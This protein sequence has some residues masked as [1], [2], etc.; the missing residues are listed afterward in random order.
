LSVARSDYVSPAAPPA[1]LAAWAVGICFFISGA[2]G[3]IYQ[4]IWVR[5]MGLFY[6]N[7]TL[8]VSS[9][10]AA[11]MGGLA[12]G[13]WL[14]GAFSDRIRRPIAL[15]GVL[16]ILIGAYGLASP[17]VLDLARDYYVGEYAGRAAGTQEIALAQLGLCF[18]CLILPTALMGATLPILSAGLQRV[19]GDVKKTVG[20]LYALNTFG[21]VLGTFLTAF[22]LLPYIGVTY[23]I[24]T[25]VVANGLIGVAMILYSMLAGEPGP[26]AAEQEESEEE[27][28]ELRARRRAL[29]P[30]VKP[31]PIALLMLVFFT[32]GL[33]A[34]TL[35]VAWTRT[36]CMFLGSSVYGFALI[37]A[38]FLIGIALGS[39][40]F[41][42]WF[43]RRPVTA[44]LLG[45]VAVAIGFS[46]L[47]LST[48]F[49]YLPYSFLGIYR[50][51]SFMHPWVLYGLQFGLCLLVTLVPTTLMGMTFPIVAKLCNDQMG[52]VGNAVGKSYAANTTGAILGSALSALVFIPVLG[53][54]GTVLWFS[55]LYVIVGAG[56]LMWC[57]SYRP[58]GS[59]TVYGTATLALLVLA[60]G[61]A[62]YAPVYLPWSKGALT[63]G[64]FRANAPGE[65]DRMLA[66]ISAPD[67][68]LI[69]YAEGTSATVSVNMTRHD[70]EVNKWLTV[71]GKT[72][73]STLEGDT[74]TQYLTG[75][76]P[77]LLNENP[78]RCL[79][80]GLGSGC[81][82]AA[83][84][85]YDEVKRVEV[86]EIEEQVLEGAKLMTELNRGV[87]EPGVEPK[88]EVRIMDGR[89]ALLGNEGAYDVIISE[90]S[91]PWI[92]GVSSLF[93]VE[94]YEAC[95]RALTPTGTYCQWA[96]AY[97]L[98]ERTMRMMFATVQKVF[99][100]ATVWR[101][102]TAD[103]LFIARKDNAP[104]NYQ[105]LVRKFE[106]NPALKQ[107]LGSLRHASPGGILASYVMGPSELKA[108]A[109]TGEIN[110]D[111]LPLLEFW[112]PRGLYHSS[113]DSNFS[114]IHELADE[115]L[116][117]MA[118]FDPSPAEARELHLDM[119]AAHLEKAGDSVPGLAREARDLL[120][121]LLDSNPGDARAWALLGE[122]EDAL[123]NEFP[124][125]H[126]YER[127]V[128]LDPQDHR[129]LERL[130]RLLLR[131]GLPIEAAEVARQAA[132]LRPRDQDL[133]DLLEHAEERAAEAQYRATS[134][135]VDT[136]GPGG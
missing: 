86:A 91:N 9:V 36:L 10:I 4:N 90:P 7:T 54:Q 58:M 45:W 102:T 21:A 72:D 119:A 113:E 125:R 123:G 22:L 3:L 94:H 73:A 117:R 135:D 11:F 106:E 107:D 97:E 6:G 127:A 95:K 63:S 40:L 53:L 16:E 57:V 27:R 130:T 136:G 30:Y 110:T 8:A 120:L 76:L 61:A 93:T 24:V 29:M 34:L 118:G 23:S 134:A 111:D 68:R 99:P 77:V 25:A 62:V 51:F 20:N 79:L 18:V 12:L 92:A 50:G 87:L 49:P 31:F 122:A 108:V 69:F 96:Q 67:D 105:R 56:V 70:G 65:T 19:L 2:T 116:P 43:G 38:S 121:P 71:N 133:Q 66:S 103:Y 89:T 85:T 100:N 101:T 15:Y 60:V 132:S 83:M 74:I 35:E 37:L 59:Y 17:H 5:L 13:A 64:V 115:G 81:S 98:D 80:I 55:A 128:E 47:G 33:S 32:T 41:V 88:L 1:R 28:Q 14:I 78:E 104:V 75:H 131:G 109:T 112:A 52:R 26:E 129:T 42:L 124:A 39:Y 48:V 46:C 44:E 82:A 126:A 114:W 84:T